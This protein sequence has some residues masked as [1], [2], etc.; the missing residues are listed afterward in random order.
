MRPLLLFTHAVSVAAALAQPKHLVVQVHGISGT[1]GDLGYLKRRLEADDDVAVLACASNEGFLKTFDGVAAGAA[2]VARE[3]RAE[4]ARRPTLETISVVGNSLGGLY[5]RQAVAA[6]YDDANRTICGL[7]PLAFVTT[8]APHLGSRRARWS[9]FL[10]PLA[11]LAPRW[12]AQSGRDVFR[13]SPV[14]E[15]FA[16]ERLFLEPL[17]A[18]RARRAY[19]TARGDFMVPVASALFTALPPAALARQGERLEDRD[20]PA[21]GAAYLVRAAAYDGSRAALPADERRL[22]EGLDAVGFDRVLVEFPSAGPLGAP[23][24]HN[25]LVALERPPAD[26]RA[27]LLRGVEG[28]DVGRPVMDGLARWL[29]GQAR[30]RDGAA[31]TS[32]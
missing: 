30:A 7:E 4:V 32:R 6:L 20:A 29:L 1:A 18:F 28:T 25:K 15:A 19:G 12:F 16:A 11:P 31:S 21:G 26:P 3:V 23:L 17:R 8:A 27:T 5:G 9:P 24:A 13:Q 2:R 10:R 22:A 14:L